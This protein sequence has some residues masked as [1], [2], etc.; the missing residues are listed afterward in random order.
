[1]QLHDKHNISQSSLSICM[2]DVMPVALL[3]P[4]ITARSLL[5]RQKHLFSLSDYHLTSLVLGVF[6]PP[7]A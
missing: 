5:L 4:C 3:S 1:M 6:M 2:F 7:K